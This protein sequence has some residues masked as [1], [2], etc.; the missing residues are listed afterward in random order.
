MALN[1]RC[2]VP[3]CRWFGCHQIVKSGREKEER[4][5]AFQSQ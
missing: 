1:G 4:K 2:V 3:L 5:I